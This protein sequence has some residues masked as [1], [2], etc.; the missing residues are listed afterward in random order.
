MSSPQPAAETTPANSEGMEPNSQYAAYL[1]NSNPAATL[2]A[3]DGVV[4]AVV[5]V[6]SRTFLITTHTDY[7][8]APSG[9]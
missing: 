5:T 6:G 2:G 9:A 7:V 4:A 3:L 8:R 1:K